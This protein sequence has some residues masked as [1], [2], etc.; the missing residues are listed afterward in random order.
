MVDFALEIKNTHPINIK[1]IELSQYRIDANIKKS[2]IL[3][4]AAIGEMKKGKFDLAINDFLAQVDYASV[5]Q[6]IEKNFLELISKNDYESILK[7]FNNKGIIHTSG[8]SQL[9]GLASKNS[10]FLNFVIGILKEK[11]EDSK[12]IEFNIRNMIEIPI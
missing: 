4:N 6:E 2:I 12:A 7:V 10:E 3:Y 8:L 5:Y 11:S 1:E 9:C